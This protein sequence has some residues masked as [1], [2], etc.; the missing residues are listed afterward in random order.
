MWKKLYMGVDVLVSLKA[1][2]SNA[3]LHNCR[4]GLGRY[5]CNPAF[6][7]RSADQREMPG[8]PRLGIFGSAPVTEDMTLSRLAFS[9]MSLRM[10]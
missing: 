10:A 7:V 3:E 4:S 1:T 9:S 6:A 5:C 2:T 8:I